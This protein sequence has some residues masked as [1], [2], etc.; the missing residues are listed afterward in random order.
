ML[1]P[2]ERRVILAV[3]PQIPVLER[4]PDLLGKLDAKL[5]LDRTDLDFKVVHN[6]QSHVVTLARAAERIPTPFPATLSAP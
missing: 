1:L 4:L 6:F 3:L 5:V 2:L